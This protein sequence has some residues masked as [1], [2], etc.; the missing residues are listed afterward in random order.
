MGSKFGFLINTFYGIEY[1]SASIQVR[2]KLK[3]NF[4]ANIISYNLLM[5]IKTVGQI[6]RSPYVT[7]KGLILLL[8]YLVH[9]MF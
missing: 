3:H 1:I 7:S 9:E 4:E 5:K 8:K 6:S 2:E